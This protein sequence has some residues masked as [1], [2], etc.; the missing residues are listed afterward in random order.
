MVKFISW[1][2][3][4]LTL[5]LGVFSF[6]LSFNSLTD[7]AAQHNVSIPFIIPILL[8]FGM[9]VFSLNALSKSIEGEKANWQWVLII[10]SSLIAGIF[11]IIHANNDLISQALAALPSVI[12]LLS[13]ETFLSQIKNKTKINLKTKDLEIKILELTQELNLKDSNFEELQIQFN[14]EKENSKLEFET[15]LKDFQ[16]LIV[17]MENKIEELELQNLNYRDQVKKLK[18]ETQVKVQ[19]PISSSKEVT[20][21]KLIKFYKSNPNGSVEE[22]AQFIGRSQGSVYNYL[23]ELEEENVIHK[24]GN[25]VEILER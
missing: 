4:L 14:L 16:N 6:I 1:L 20:I 9:I 19:K 13:F 3:G 7:L 21:S 10:G 18:T 23:K 17:E 25:G 12:L 2:T 8:E 15:K 11:N 5:A 24:N 22:A